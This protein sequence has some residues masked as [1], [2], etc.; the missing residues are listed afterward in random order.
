[1]IDDIRKRITWLDVAWL[2]F[3][4]GLAL[5]PPVRELHKQLTLLAIGILQLSEGALIA[6]F[7]GRGRIYTVVLK[8]LL[9]TVELFY[10]GKRGLMEDESAE[11]L[12][13][14]E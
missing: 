1:M 4:V 11:E 13:H 14:A 6:H 5:L 2:V 7:P 3:L 12:V 10:P 8:L 9:A